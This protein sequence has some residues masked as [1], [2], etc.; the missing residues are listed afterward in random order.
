MADPRVRLVV[1]PRAGAGAAGRILPDVVRALQQRGV[2]YEI[3]RTSAP[4]D[5]TRI[6]RSSF[7]DGIDIIAV[8]GGDGTLNEVA[9]AY[10][11]DAGQ[12][13]PG[14][15]IALLPA[16]TGGDLRRTLRL[17]R[18]P[19]QMVD[20]MCDGTSESIDLGIA[21]LVGWNGEP[22]TRAFV[23]VTSFGVGGA[24]DR[25]VNQSPKWLG[26]KAAFFLGTARALLSYRNA[27]VRVL[28]DG[29]PFLDGPVFN[30]AVANGRF[31]GGGMLIAPD[32]EPSDGVLEVVALGD[33]S[34]PEVIG[35]AGR[36]YRGT[37]TS[38]PK[39]TV[40]RGK[41]IEAEPA[42]AGG[43]VWLDMDGETPG[44]LPVRI[45]VAPRAL[46]IRT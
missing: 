24:T 23:N 10:L 17:P 27:P 20:R 7:E 22:L 16:G 2:T 5:A 26:G 39:V 38:H 29:S 32:A 3:A 19:R 31:F 28:V 13:R 25:L 4:G 40:T 18:D 43:E 41:A 30:V 36:I 9:Q 34:R 1:N 37:H 42:R 21:E 12:P 11:D 15:E 46:R 45:R 14:P 8:T 33:L 6:A 44:K 35:L